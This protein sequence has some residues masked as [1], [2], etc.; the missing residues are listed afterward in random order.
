MEPIL[1]VRNLSKTFT[2]RGRETLSAVDNVSFS[3]F[4]G[5][6]LGLVGVS[7]C[8]K[9]TI[10][11]L[12]TRLIEPTAGSVFIDGENVT[13]LR[14]SGLRRIYGKIQMVFQTPTGSFDPVRTLG[15]G[16]S[17]SLRNLNIKKDERRKTTERLLKQCGLPPEYAYRYPHEVSGGE[18][19]RAAIARALAVRPE[20]LILD[21][22][23][24]SL[25]VNVQSHILH[26]L[27][28]LKNNFGLSYLFIC[29]NLGLVQQFC[30]R[31]LVMDEGRIIEE[32]RPDDVILHP[33][34]E[35]T[36]LLASSMI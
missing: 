21:E 6:V 14:F 12:I 13:K 36:K 32:G 11:K 2:K 33:K 4:R 17:E 22:A 20:I 26:L 5:E 31:V 28:S 18:C 3:L 10:A 30:D 19:Q 34:K 9:S 7:G 24:S 35:Y 27:S 29:H 15:D 23:T 1:E 25:D 16:I 8:G